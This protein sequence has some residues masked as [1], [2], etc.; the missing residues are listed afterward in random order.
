MQYVRQFL[1]KGNSVV[2]TARTP[3]KAK[4]LHKLAEKDSKLTLTQLDVT[5]MESIKVTAPA[6]TQTFQCFGF[7]ASLHAFESVQYVE[8]C[9]ISGRAHP[10]TGS[11]SSCEALCSSLQA[12]AQK[13]KGQVKQV[14]VGLPKHLLWS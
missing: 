3:A 12:W 10:C 7:W 8:D 2:A 14:D 9:V 11:C 13:L 4:E 6:A 5:S 1:E